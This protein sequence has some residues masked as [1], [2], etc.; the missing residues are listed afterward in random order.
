MI[1]NEKIFFDSNCNDRDYL[2]LWIVL[3]NLAL[4]EE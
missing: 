4:L 3:V 2:L 1:V